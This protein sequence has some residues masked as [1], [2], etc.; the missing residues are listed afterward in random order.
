MKYE[1][2]NLDKSLVICRIDRDQEIIS[3]LKEIVRKQNIYGGFF[4]GI[5]AVKD[6]ILSYYDLS[7]K[8]YIDKEFK[9]EYEIVSL[10]GNISYIYASDEVLVHAHMAISDKNFVV[11]GG[12]LKKAIVSVTCELFILTVNDKLE[13][14][15]N[16]E[17][18]LYLLKP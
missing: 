6:V 18:G 14:V 13:R 2:T 1:V 5:G 17:I 3:V 8:K 15:F 4:K 16:E 7:S 10:L 11:Y 9:G 12:H